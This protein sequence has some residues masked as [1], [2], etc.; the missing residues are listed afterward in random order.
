MTKK[1]FERPLVKEKLEG[2]K[3]FQLD[4]VEYVFQRLYT[5]TDRT[6]KFLIADEVGLGKTLVARG[7]IAKAV[8]YLWDT[9]ERIDVVY[10][11]S[12]QNIAR[13]NID[14][15]NISSNREFQHAARATLLPVSIKQLKDNKINFISL[16]PKTSLDLRSSTGVMWERALLF[17]ILKREWDV[18]LGTLRN[19]MRGD[20]GK[21]SFTRTLSYFNS[22]QTIDADLEKDFVQA[23]RKKPDIKALYN[24][25]ADMIG[26]RRKY[27][28]HEMRRKRNQFLGKLRGVLASSSLEALEPD[29][30]ILDEFQR[31]KY[32]LD[33]ENELSLLAQKLFDFPDVKVLLLSATPYKMY[34]LHGESDENHYEDFERTVEF[35]LD[36]IPNN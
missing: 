34:T 8:D 20:A 13:Q 31:F 15:L 32:L 21:K 2:L 18:Q 14:R 33:E 30:V 27:L 26:G 5:D 29:L 7:L 22:S 1:D 19:V 16:T 28:S 36:L 23:L 10:I 25:A 24:Q 3:D 6:S 12:N 9:V 35:L 4:T 17:N 11:C